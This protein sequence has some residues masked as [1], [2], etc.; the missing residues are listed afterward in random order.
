MKKWKLS[1]LK[2]IHFLELHNDRSNSNSRSDSS[3]NRRRTKCPLLRSPQW[4]TVT[5]SGRRIGSRA[6]YKC[7]FGR[8]LKGN[9]YR[10]CL[11]G[12]HWSGTQPQC[13]SKCNVI[14]S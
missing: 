4:G 7:H 1:F 3:S 6:T 10:N 5:V 8:L 13:L 14:Y 12:G 9:K 11:K 2:L